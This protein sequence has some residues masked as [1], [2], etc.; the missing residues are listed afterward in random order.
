MHVQKIFVFA[1]C[2]ESLLLQSSYDNIDDTNLRPKIPY[3]STLRDMKAETTAE[4]ITTSKRNTRN[5]LKSCLYQS[6]DVICT[7]MMS[8]QT[9]RKK[10]LLAETRQ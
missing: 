3:I 4:I 9:G 1:I 10:I 2:N 6:A 7:F 8:K 5:K